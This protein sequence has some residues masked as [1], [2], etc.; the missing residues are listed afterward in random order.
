MKPSSLLNQH[1]MVRVAAV[2]PVQHLGDV[3]ANVREITVCA[4]KAE[5]DGAQIIV[6]PELSLTG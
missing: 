6:F 3:A 2:T 4:T 1:Q 5:K